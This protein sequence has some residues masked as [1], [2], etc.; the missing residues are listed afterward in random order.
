[1]SSEVNLVK[2]ER[3]LLVERATEGECKVECP[4]G[5]TEE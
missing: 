4:C 3:R 2:M 1:M 5:V